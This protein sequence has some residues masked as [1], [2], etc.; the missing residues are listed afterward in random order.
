[1]GDVP[2][3]GPR[4]LGLRPCLRSRDV[5]PSLPG[6]NVT[7]T[8]IADSKSFGQSSPGPFSR[9]IQSQNFDDCCIRQLAS[10]IVLPAQ[11]VLN[12]VQFRRKPPE[13]GK[14]VVRAV[15]VDMVGLIPR[16]TRADKGL[17]NEAMH[18]SFRALISIPVEADPQ[19]SPIDFLRSQDTARPRPAPSPSSGLPSHPSEIRYLVWPS[20]HGPPQFVCH[21]TAKVSVGYNGW[22]TVA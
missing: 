12:R 14:S 6:Q 8:P 18:E 10:G 7:H 22:G 4:G 5:T 2:P 16:R 3:A 17:Q 1:M 9:G 11:P 15:P 13:I 19:V 20:G 21:H